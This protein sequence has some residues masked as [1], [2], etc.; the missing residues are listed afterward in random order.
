MVSPGPLSKGHAELAGD[1]FACHLPWRATAAERCSEC[2]KPADVG[3]RTTKGVPIV[4]ATP[5]IAF[6]QQLAQQDCA[7]CH[8]DHVGPRQ[9]LRDRKG[10]AHELL[11]PAVQQQCS[12]C[13]ATPTNR[14][15]ENLKEGCAQC[16]GTRSWKVD[17]FDHALLGAS[18]DARCQSCHTAPADRLHAR[19]DGRCATCHATQAWKPATFD[20][21]RH[22]VL[23]RDHDAECR[24]CHVGN[25]YSRYTCYGCH[26]HSPAS[27][28]AEHAE[29][30]IRNFDNCVECHRSAD[31][32]GR[33]GGSRRGRD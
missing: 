13:H 27:I 15:H 26:E 16:H 17:A 4:T 11:R 24:T 9:T 10:F 18:A 2:H 12:G 30:G 22:F 33:A 14:V 23:D 32:E 31:D 6:H 29:E 25:D 19:L 5:R 20:H 3:L 7:S 8:S 21:D 1:C 28:R